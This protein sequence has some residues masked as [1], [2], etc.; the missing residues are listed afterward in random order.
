MERP[1]E[2]EPSDSSQP[3]QGDTRLNAP[4]TTRQVADYD[5]S[6]LIGVLK[7]RLVNDPRSNDQRHERDPSHTASPINP[8]GRSC[9]HTY[10]L[11]ATSLGSTQQTNNPDG[12]VTGDQN[13]HYVR[14][15]S[16][17]KH[18]CSSVLMEERRRC[19]ENHGNNGLDQPLV[20]NL[21]RA[22]GSEQRLIRILG[23][24]Q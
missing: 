24:Q 12:R 1:H 21:S 5:L 19:G 4:D 17:N 3:D 20:G 10:S 9:H 22:A 15:L 18:C 11:D 6:G 2:P 7:A 13:R 14:F 16:P 23:Y 8:S